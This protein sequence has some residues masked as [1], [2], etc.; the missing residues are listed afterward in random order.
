MSTKSQFANL[1]SEANLLADD[2]V[3]RGRATPAFLRALRTA[4]HEFNESG[5]I[6]NHL[7]ALLAETKSMKAALPSRG[8]AVRRAA[9]RLASWIPKGIFYAAILLV[10]VLTSLYTMQY[11]AIKNNIVHLQSLQ[12]Q[13]I[14]DVAFRFWMMSSE[15]NIP[16]GFLSEP[17]PISFEKDLTL[18]KLE[19]IS[20]INNEV[21][22]YEQDAQHN[23][24]GAYGD[25]LLSVIPNAI[26]HLFSSGG[27]Q[28]QLP[29]LDCSA[30]AP[31]GDLTPEASY[32]KRL[33][34]DGIAQLLPSSQCGPAVQPLESTLNLETQLKERYGQIVLPIL[35][36][37][38]GAIVYHVRLMLRSDDFTLG[39]WRINL[40]IL[41][42][43]LAGVSGS[44]FVSALGHEEG[45]SLS[46][47][48]WLF[49][50]AFLMGF[51]L[52][53]FFTT[54]DRLVEFAEA[55][56]DPRPVA[57]RGQPAPTI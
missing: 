31:E 23:L 20:Q 14:M 32:L 28:T 35:L 38:L 41:L 30:V 46:T 29:Q 45:G 27:D 24:D 2:A 34:L 44:V 25:V 11:I 10:S 43:G 26:N 49:L 19:K 16:D 40:R 37:M 53:L 55:R 52:E 33:H 5:K 13:N 36:G 8:F 50:L 39:Y 57:E 3:R 47:S 17:R 54:L 21:T 4:E 6:E 1:L 7:D 9:H 12:S 15:M 18:E 48:I 42:G 22:V 56:L 51:S